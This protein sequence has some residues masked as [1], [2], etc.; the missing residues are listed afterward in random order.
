MSYLRPIA[1]ALLCFVSAP[2]WAAA[3]DVT[4]LRAEL[5]ALKADYANKVTALE[6]RIDQL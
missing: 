6:A 3:D 2:L 4:A 1:A 5:E